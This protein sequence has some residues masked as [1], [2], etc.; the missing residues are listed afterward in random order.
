L[1]V[2][3][4]KSGFEEIGKLLSEKDYQKTVA[5]T[6]AQERAKVDNERRSLMNNS[7]DIVGKES[8]AAKKYFSDNK[9]SL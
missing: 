5:Q 2:E 1:G 8:N 9:K 4:N 3:K 7:K 6:A